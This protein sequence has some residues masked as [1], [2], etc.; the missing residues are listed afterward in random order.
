[1]NDRPIFHEG[2]LDAQRRAHENGIAARVSKVIKPIIVAGA[3]PFIREQSMVLAG[4]VDSVGQVWASILYGHPGFLDPAPDA[5]KLLIHLDQALPQPNDPLL[6]NVAERREVGLLLIEFSTRRRLR[7]NGPVERVGDTLIVEVAESY[8]ICPKYI[9]K[10]DIQILKQTDEDQ[11]SAARSGVGLETRHVELIKRADTFF[12]ASSHATYGPDVSHRGGK[13]GF[14]KILEDGAFR[15]PDFR[16]NSMLSSFGNFT[17]NPNAGVAFADY[18]S[19][20]I[21]QLTGQASLFWDQLDPEGETGGT[22]RFW[23]FR[24]ESWRESE[25]PVSIHER[26]LEYSPFNP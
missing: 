20:S 19:R 1:L 16:G 4:S 10:R 3:V 25:M 7:V 13:Q 6:V 11:E 5:K 9:Q 15:I 26:F 23:E 22:N 14:V 18:Q 2:E 12:V 17:L 24:A 8:A 21:L